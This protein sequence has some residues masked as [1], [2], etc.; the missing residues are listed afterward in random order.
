MYHTW[1]EWQ[2]SAGFDSWIAS[3]IKRRKNAL[4]EIVYL[5]Y[6]HQKQ[7]RELG[8]TAAHLQRAIEYHAR[9]DCELAQHD[10]RFLIIEP[11]ER[12]KEAKKI[13]YLIDSL[14]N[15]ERLALIEQLKMAGM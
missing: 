8:L 7:L 5:K 11:K 14:T 3:M 10:G 2:E 4:M 9:L 13:E 6:Q 1:I 12:K 15:E